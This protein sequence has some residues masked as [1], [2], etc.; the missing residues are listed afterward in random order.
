MQSVYKVSA[1]TSRELSA[2]AQPFYMVSKPTS[3]GLSAGSA[4]FF[5]LVLNLKPGNCLLGCI[6]FLRFP[7]LPP[8]KPTYKP[9]LCYVP[10]IFFL[11]CRWAFLGCLI[12]RQK[13]WGSL[14]LYLSLSVSLSLFLSLSLSL[15]LSLGRNTSPPIRLRPGDYSSQDQNSI[16]PI[17]RKIDR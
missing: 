8:L 14:Y 15:S 9:T 3:R 6:L 16:E 12:T 2:W 5:L 11:S 4:A 7:N 17:W 10:V 13:H 1:P